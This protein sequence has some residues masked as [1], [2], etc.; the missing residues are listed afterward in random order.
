[1]AAWSGRHGDE[2]HRKFYQGLSD[3]L[4]QYVE[5]EWTL[6]EIQSD[7]ATLRD[8]LESVWRQSGNRPEQLEAVECPSEIKYLW[9][10]FCQLHARRGSSGMG[11]NPIS[12]AEIEAWSRL[13]HVK[14]S[15]FEVGVLDRLE[16]LYLKRAAEQA[17]KP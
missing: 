6:S 3:A 12:Y 7:G 13:Q 17:H 2:H 9:F 4:I 14:L 15:A 5:N 1:V 16:A 11:P 10:Y 8:H